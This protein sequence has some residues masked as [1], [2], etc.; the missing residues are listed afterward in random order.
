[1]IER[2]DKNGL[3]ADVIYDDGNMEQVT[4]DHIRRRAESP[5][6]EAVVQQLCNFLLDVPIP[7][8]YQH[9]LILDSTAPVD[10]RGEM[11]WMQSIRKK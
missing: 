7:C 11:P 4:L 3:L 5:S 1:M 8:N 2:C 6:A 9:A 10:E